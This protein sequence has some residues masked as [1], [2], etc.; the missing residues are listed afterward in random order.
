MVAAALRQHQ[1]A[2]SRGGNSSSQCPLVKE[3]ATKETSASAMQGAGSRAEP[4]DSNK[5]KKRKQ[6]QKSER[7]INQRKEIINL[8]GRI[9]YC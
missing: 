2:G 5:E 9:K 8:I 7:R 3:Q 6:E 4:G 1:G